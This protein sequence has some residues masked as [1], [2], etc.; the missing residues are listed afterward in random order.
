MSICDTSIGLYIVANE[1]AEIE[2][3]RNSVDHNFK[4]IVHDFV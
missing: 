4:N 3:L 2:K 1:S